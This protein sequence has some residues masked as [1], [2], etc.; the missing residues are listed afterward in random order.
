VA[1]GGKAEFR[2]LRRRGEEGHFYIKGDG[3]QA[4]WAA[5]LGTF[6]AENTRVAAR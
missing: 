4:G 5:P 6:L 2:L 1:A 3:D